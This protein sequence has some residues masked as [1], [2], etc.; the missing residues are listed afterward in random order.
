MLNIK[1]A[2]ES[3]DRRY[4]FITPNMV[5]D[6][7]LSVYAF[8]LYSHL[9]RVAGETGQCW[10][11]AR[12]LAK[13]CRMSVHAVSSAK[14]ELVEHGL[15]AIQCEKTPTGGRDYH[16]I[17]ITNVW[18]K[19]VL[20][21]ANSP[22]EQ[23][24]TD[25]TLQGTEAREQ[26]TDTREQGT[27]ARRKKNPLRRTK[28]E[29][30]GESATAA[31][32]AA[33]FDEPLPN[34]KP[35]AQQPANP[36]MPGKEQI[37][38]RIWTKVTDFATF[39]SNS[40]AEDIRRIEAIYNRNEWDFDKTVAELGRYYQNWCDQVSPKTHRKYSK[41]NTGWLDWAIAGEMGGAANLIPTH[42]DSLQAAL[43]RLKMP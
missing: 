30:E 28:E 25:S 33:S 7:G 24:G 35:P 17:S 27:V 23:Q 9:K 40:M 3:S 4:F 15:I 1:I 10:Q 34:Q 12:T 8:R 13:S 42:E 26:G 29:E 39:F 20:R 19:N 43:R 36:A 31:S 37:F 32:S 14:R 21:Y 41:A 18:P 11:S 2:D 6:L 22:Q 5:D 38:E 16:Q